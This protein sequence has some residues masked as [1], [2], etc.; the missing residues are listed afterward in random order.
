M[1]ATYAIYYARI[2]EKKRS[3]EYT[4]NVLYIFKCARTEKY[5]VSCFNFARYAAA[6]VA[7]QKIPEG[8]RYNSKCQCRY[9]ISKYIKR[10]YTDL[11]QDY[12][13]LNIILNRTG[14]LNKTLNKTYSVV[15]SI[16]VFV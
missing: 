6:V 4:A 10:R 11:G 15:S 16:F 2:Y 13:D 14:T 9:S 7:R 3:D 8:I 1:F 5:P 12:T